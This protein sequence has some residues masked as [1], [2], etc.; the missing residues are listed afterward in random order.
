MP[1]TSP[2]NGGPRGAAT[3]RFCVLKFLNAWTR[4]TPMKRM[5]KGYADE[6]H[7]QDLHRHSPQAFDQY[8]DIEVQKKACPTIEKS[9]IS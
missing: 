1:S 7:G 6:M 3:R 5:G 2:R 4:F 9:Q 8:G